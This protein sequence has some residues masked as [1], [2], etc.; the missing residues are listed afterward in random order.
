MEESTKRTWDVALGITVPLIAVGG[1]VLGAW[2]FSHKLSEDARLDFERRLWLADRD[3]CITLSD[4]VGKVVAAIGPED[5]AANEDRLEENAA[6]FEEAYWGPVLLLD[7]PEIEAATI[8]F[9]NALDDFRGGW[10]R[11]IAV[12]RSATDLIVACRRATRDRA[13][14]DRAE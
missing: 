6:A 2:Q 8:S 5:A 13:P 3:A 9:R 7:D 14:D 4:L 11:S 12:K 1:L 10:A